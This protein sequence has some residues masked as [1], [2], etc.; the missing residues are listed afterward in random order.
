MLNKTAL[1][2]AASEKKNFSSISYYK[3]LADF[4]T[5]GVANLD[6]G[7]K[8]GNFHEEKYLTLLHT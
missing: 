4:H 2:L 1:G 3:L 8:A 6:P 7:G 5:T